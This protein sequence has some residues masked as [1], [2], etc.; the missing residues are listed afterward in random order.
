MLEPPLTR[1]I[2]QMLGLVSVPLGRSPYRAALGPLPPA[3]CREPHFLRAGCRCH[4]KPT[5]L[6]VGPV[7]V[8]GACSGISAAVNSS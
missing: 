1:E 6:W 5:R 7:L 3:P 2:L 4:R 8:C